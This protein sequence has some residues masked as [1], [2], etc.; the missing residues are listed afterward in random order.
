MP[1]S[2]SAKRM[3]MEA[4]R[5]TIRGLEQSE[6]LSPDDPTLRE[7][8]SSILRRIARREREAQHDSAPRMI[9]E[10]ESVDSEEESA[11]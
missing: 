5:S 1:Y 9:A 3:L 2:D 4:L 10:M 7:I 6:E 11:A 8:K